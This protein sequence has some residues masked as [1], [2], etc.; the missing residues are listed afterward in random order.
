MNCFTPQD[1]L[2]TSLMKSIPRKVFHWLQR[3]EYDFAQS[4]SCGELSWKISPDCGKLTISK[5]AT[6]SISWSG[7]ADT[8]TDI[9]GSD[10]RFCDISNNLDWFTQVEKNIYDELDAHERYLDELDSRVVGEMKSDNA[11]LAEIEQSK[12]A[13]AAEK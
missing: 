1:E 6:V 5:D 8:P 3:L 11:Q 10:S 7:H 2:S 9:Q 12:N 4:G 13:R